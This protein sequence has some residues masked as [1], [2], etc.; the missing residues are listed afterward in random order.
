[1]P[2]PHFISLRGRGFRALRFAAAKRPGGGNAGRA[3]RQSGPAVPATALREH[4]PH[5]GQQNRS[6][7]ERRPLS[8]ELPDPAGRKGDVTSTA[9]SRGRQRRSCS[10]T[11]TRRWSRYTGDRSRAGRLD[12]VK[13]RRFFF[14]HHHE[15]DDDSLYWTT[16][17]YSSVPSFAQLGSIRQEASGRMTLFAC[18]ARL[19]RKANERPLAEKVCDGLRDK[20]KP[21][22]GTMKRF[23]FFL[24]RFLWTSLRQKMCLDVMV[25]KVKQ[26]NDK[27]KGHYASRGTSSKVDEEAPAPPAFQVDDCSN[28]CIEDC[29]PPATRLEDFRSLGTKKTQQRRF[30]FS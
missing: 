25:E 28:R 12:M 11:G 29:A 9:T 27:G 21:G 17:P 13:L 22:N 6:D 24:F 2:F 5:Q 18:C 16:N 23:P 8:R 10:S 19:C 26:R 4:V 15:A 14:P 20:F 1:M 30:V 7:S 3:W